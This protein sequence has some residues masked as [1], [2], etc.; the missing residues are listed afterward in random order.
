[1]NFAVPYWLLIER[2]KMCTTLCNFTPCIK[3]YCWKFNF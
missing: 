1:M 3:R 2:K